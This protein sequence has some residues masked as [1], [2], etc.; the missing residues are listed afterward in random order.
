M[1]AVA[2]M[3]FVEV[4]LFQKAWKVL[5]CSPEDLRQLQIQLSLCWTSHSGN[6]SSEK[7][8]VCKGRTWQK[9]G[10]AGDLCRD[11]GSP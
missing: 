11:S 9:R 3:E 10:S 6:G 1:E 2:E 7:A 8:P 4:G 5:G